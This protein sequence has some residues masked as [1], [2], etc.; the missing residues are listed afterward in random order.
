MAFHVDETDI[1]YQDADVT[2][3]VSF[4]SP[5]FLAEI[6]ADDRANDMHEAVVTELT[7]QLKAG[8]A[9]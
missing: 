9:L 3:P 8:V 2:K 5:W 6:D 4:K 1:R 7:N